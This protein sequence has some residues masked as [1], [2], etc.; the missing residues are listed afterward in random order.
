M[1]APTPVQDQLTAL[2]K[3]HGSLQ[4][5]NL[6]EAPTWLV[7]DNN[8]GF[9]S[10]TAETTLAIIKARNERY[11]SVVLKITPEIL[12][13]KGSELWSILEIKD[14]E[15]LETFWQQNK[16]SLQRHVLHQLK[17]A[18]ESEILSKLGSELP[19]F[20]PLP[21]AP[22]ERFIVIDPGSRSGMKLIT[23]NDKGEEISHSIIFPHEPQSQWQQGLRK[24]GQFMQT[25]RVSAICLLEGE[26]FFESR[27]FLIEWLRDQDK[28]Y[29]VFQV[30][31]IG[32][33]ILCDRHSDENHDNLHN[34]ARQAAQLVVDAQNCFDDIPLQCLLQNPLKTVLNPWYLEKA[35]RKTWQENFNEVKPRLPDPLYTNQI[36]SLNDLKA[37]QKL[38]GRIMNIADF[39]YFLSVGIEQNGLLHNSQL[40]KS[41][42]YV[43]GEVVDVYVEKVNLGKLQYSLTLRK[44]KPNRPNEKKKPQPQGNSAMADALKAAL[45]KKP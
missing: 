17:L 37:G 16:Q 34:R 23:A 43:L 11:L 45:N 25:N 7:I 6:R 14:P 26:G 10:L 13:Q 12:W 38:K 1:T 31:D 19:R 22:D 32:I 44:P 39:G 27:Q 29:P 33:P 41:D 36:N 42:K 28:H 2:L 8:P 15:Q 24:F 5:H 21:L 9:A 35:L 20:E 40:N 30:P 4:V 3:E 18:A